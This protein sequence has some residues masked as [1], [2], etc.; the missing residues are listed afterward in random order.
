MR[1]MCC[2]MGLAIDAAVTLGFA[3]AVTLPQTGNIG[4]GGFMIVRHAES[5]D[6]IAIDYREK[7][8]NPAIWGMLLD[9]DGN[10]DGKLSRY[11][12]IAA[13]VPGTVAGLAMALEKY[14]TLT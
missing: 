6:L 12:L 9:D 7:A 5:G 10:V 11:S 4:G 14:G 3:L 8:P 1:L 13:G 2:G